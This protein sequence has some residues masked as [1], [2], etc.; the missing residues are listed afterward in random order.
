MKNITPSLQLDDFSINDWI[1][2]VYED[3]ITEELNWYIGIV[4]EVIFEYQELKV[5]FWTYRSRKGERGTSF[6]P[7]KSFSSVPIGRILKKLT[8]SR[9]TRRTAEFSL[10]QQDE[11]EKLFQDF[12]E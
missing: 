1:G 12:K 8:P 2:C 11:L 10:D 5:S 7:D 6:Q 4:D 9:R 3:H